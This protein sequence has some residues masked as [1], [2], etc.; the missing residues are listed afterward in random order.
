MK[1]FK[2]KKIILIWDFDAP[3]GQVNSTFPY[4]YSNNNFDKEQSNI[5]YALNKLAEYNIKSCFAITGFSAEKGSP[6]F[7]FPEFINEISKQGHEI[8]S[9][10]WK[11]EWIPLFT[12]DQ[13]TKSL[14]RSKSILEA[15]I[16]YRQDVVG[17]VPPHNKPET[18]IKRGA[19]SFG[20]RG[21]WPFFKMGNLENVF[22]LLIELQYKWIRISHN[23]IKYKFG[24]VKKNIKVR[25]RT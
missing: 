15:A 10:N 24:M 14:K 25:E 2:K 16:E 4:N 20:D 17:F 21:L 9:H 1:I 7:N 12:E 3:I 22:N 18:W 8:A 19:F 13:I 23:P 6:P 11:H 5:M